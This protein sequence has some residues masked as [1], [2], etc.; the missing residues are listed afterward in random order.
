MLDGVKHYGW[1]VSPYSAKTRAY[2]RFAKV[3][4]EDVEPSAFVLKRRIARGVGRL[5]MPTVELGDGRWLQDS[6]VIIDFFDAQGGTPS[7]CPPGSNQAFA[8]ALVEF[9]ADE[10]LPMA[11]LHYR[12]NNEENAAFALDEFARSAFPRLPRFLGRP[13][14]KGMAQK[15]QS[16]LQVLGVSEELHEP[17]ESCVRALIRSL[18]AHF[19]VS[20]YLLGERPCLGDFALYGPLWAHLYRDPA[21]RPLFEGSPALRAWMARVG[22]GAPMEGEFFSDDEVPSSLNP[23]FTYAL[24]DQWAWVR[25]LVGAIDRYVEAHPDAKRVPRALGSAEF[26]FAGQRSTRKL[27]TFVQYKAQRSEAAFRVDEPKALAWME[28]V[29]G[30]GSGS[31]VVPEIANPFVLQHFKPVL[32]KRVTSP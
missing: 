22:E 2:L 1:Q 21:S 17:V 19:S 27:A 25:T 12:W 5:I 29:L 28:S 31:G 32:A 13:L 15:M 24:Q 9:F 8:S 20:S 3:A 6:S 23:L 18:D 14:I 26:T 11:A 10:W 7:L 16:Y 30:A 4:F